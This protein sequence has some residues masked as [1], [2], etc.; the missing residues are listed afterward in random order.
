MFVQVF[1]QLSANGDKIFFVAT[2]NND[3]VYS[4][5]LD[6]A[7]VAKESFNHRSGT[8]AMVRKVCQC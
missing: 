5:D 4:F 3:D 8:Y 2:H 6:V 7:D 1:V